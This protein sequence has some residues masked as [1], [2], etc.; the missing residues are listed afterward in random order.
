MSVSENFAAM[1]DQEAVK[2]IEETQGRL[3]GQ[4]YR[5]KDGTILTQDCP[6]GLRAVRRKPAA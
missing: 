1:T 4:I 3:C 5:R 6:V 2:L